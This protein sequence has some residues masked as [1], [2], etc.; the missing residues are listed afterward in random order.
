MR[1]IKI[2]KRKH[3]IKLCILVAILGFLSHSIMGY[4]PIIGNLIAEKKLSDYATIQKGSPQK[5]ETK[6]D[7]Y[8]TKY[9]SIKGNLS[10]M[11][12]RN[13][14]YD[15]KVSEQ[16]NY[17]VLKQYSIVN[18]EFP[19]N[20]SFPS[21]NTIWTEL[22]ADDYSI[23]SQRLYLLG[24][25]N[26]EDI[27]EEESKK[28]CAIIADKFINLMG[29]DY[30]FTGI[31]IIYYDKNGGYECAIDAHGFKKLEYDEMLSKTKKVDR[32]PEDYLDWLSKQ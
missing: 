18:S 31:Q 29:E 14:I 6:Y 11:L 3:I 2:K 23:K 21:I 9:K 12:Q 16:V 26:T 28:M 7:W 4:L 24:V 17:D 15:D 5:I 32:L 8:N 13:T 1:G 22:N 25:Y 10:Y 30:N 19:Q 20:L 27:S